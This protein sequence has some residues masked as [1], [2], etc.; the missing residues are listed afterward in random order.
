MRAYSSQCLKRWVEF[1]DLK[2]QALAVRSRGVQSIRKMMNRSVATAFSAW[3]DWSATMRRCRVI[4][5][6]L[7]NAEISR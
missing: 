6:R 1:V 4:L 3:V 2:K 5:G 7:A